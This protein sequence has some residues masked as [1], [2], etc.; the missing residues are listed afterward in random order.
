MTSNG[1]PRDLLNQAHLPFPA[2]SLDDHGDPNGGGHHHAD[3]P[4]EPEPP[5]GLKTITING[6]TYELQHD[7]QWWFRTSSADGWT[8]CSAEMSALIHKRFHSS[9][10]Q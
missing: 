3:G 10:S 9:S 5:T 7:R 2:D 8:A 6:K 1:K 4:A